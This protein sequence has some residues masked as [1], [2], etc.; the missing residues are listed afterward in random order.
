MFEQL[1]KEQRRTE[2]QTESWPRRSTLPRSNTRAVTRER[3][4]AI[5]PRRF[6]SCGLGG[7]NRRSTFCFTTSRAISPRSTIFPARSRQL[8]RQSRSGL[9]ARTAPRRRCDGAPVACLRAARRAYRQP[10]SKGTPTLRYGDTDSRAIYRGD[11]AR[12]SHRTPARGAGAR[13]TR[14]VLAQR[15]LHLRPRL[16]SH[17]RWQR[18]DRHRAPAPLFSARLRDCEAVALSDLAA[19]IG[20]LSSHCG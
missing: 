16:R 8:A 10:C 19:S 5:V 14:Y 1:R 20:A 3:A 2:T 13:R 6:R 18:M 11:D 4:A 15:A 17:S 12:P 7:T 9:R